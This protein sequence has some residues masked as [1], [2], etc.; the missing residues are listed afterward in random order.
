M[1]YHIIKLDSQLE[2]LLWGRNDRQHNNARPVMSMVNG[3]LFSIIVTHVE[4]LLHFVALTHIM[5]C[6][7]EHVEDIDFSRN[8]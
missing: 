7:M 4:W 5:H 3:I 2:Y 1:E 8:T 6:F